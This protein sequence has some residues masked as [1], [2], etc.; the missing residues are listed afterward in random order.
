MKQRLMWCRSYFEMQTVTYLLVAR[1]SSMPLAITIG[2][3]QKKANKQKRRVN[4]K[5]QLLSIRRTLKRNNTLTL[6]AP[7]VWLTISH[8]LL[9]HT[10]S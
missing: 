4:G 6:A 5:C 7:W 9:S 3:I 1:P 2:R 8:N 10:A